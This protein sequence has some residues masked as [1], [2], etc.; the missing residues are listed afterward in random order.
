MEQIAFGISTAKHI[1]LSMMC[2]LFHLALSKQASSPQENS[3]EAI[4]LSYFTK[5]FIFD[6]T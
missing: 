6:E 3:V 4:G 2:I 5:T 1:A